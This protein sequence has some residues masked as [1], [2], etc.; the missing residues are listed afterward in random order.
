MV[1]RWGAVE[2]VDA[3]GDFLE[4]TSRRRQAYER[5]LRDAEA[6]GLLACD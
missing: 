5:P 2:S 1:R 4:D 6:D 3:V